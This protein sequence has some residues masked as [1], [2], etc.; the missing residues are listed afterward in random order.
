MAPMA[1]D[2]S[3]T[4]VIHSTRAE[5]Q[6]E[7]VEVGYHGP[8]RKGMSSVGGGGGDGRSPTPPPAA[9]LDAA[10]NDSRSSPC[11]SSSVSTPVASGRTP[12]RFVGAPGPSALASASAIHFQPDLL[13][14]ALDELESATNGGGKNGNGL[15][16]H[17][18]HSLSSMASNE[19][20]EREVA[21]ASGAT[22][23]FLTIEECRWDDAMTICR[24]RPE[25]AR[26]WVKSSGSDQ[27]SFDW[28]VWKRLP[29]HEAC[30]RQPPPILISSLLDA[31]PS[32]CAA[33]THFGELP[34][35][36][37]IGCGSNPESIHLLLASY[38]NAVSKPDDAGRTPFDLIDEGIEEEDRAV[39]LGSLERCFAAQHQIEAEWSARLSL[40]TKR[41]EAEV[42]R[43][44]RENRKRLVVKDMALSELA[45]EVQA[46][47]ERLGGAAAEA[48]ERE[49]EIQRRT[50]AERALAKQARVA[51][52]EVSRL[53]SA[54]RDLKKR[55]GD[56]DGTVLRHETTIERLNGRVVSLSQDLRSV[57]SMHDDLVRNDVRTVE[58]EMVKLIRLQKGFLNNV[59]DRGESI[60][61]ILTEADIEAPSGPSTPARSIGLGSTGSGAESSGDESSLGS[62][63]SRQMRG[64]DPSSSPSKLVMEDGATERAAAMATTHLKQQQLLE[65]EGREEKSNE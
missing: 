57:C 42:D 49:A 19:M 7:E 46:G 14:E 54:N 9:P 38:P 5:H 39:V 35:H 18:P 3:P 11:S 44:V 34:L 28:S 60:R 43:L 16:H 37:A 6:E 21:Y 20:T 53:R 52:G 36:L 12:G 27:T 45:R 56:L 10:T 24:E 50:R 31:Y 48:D 25:Q 26:I 15:P 41:H 58:Q 40:L 47:T 4:S 30:R 64:R 62:P 2:A 17:D 55:L 63:M 22:K 23:L 61:T 13:A 51:E 59:R 32:S 8:E 29:I 33:K 65:G 1:F